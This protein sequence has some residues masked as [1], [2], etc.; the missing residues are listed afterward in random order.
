MRLA[1]PDLYKTLDALLATLTGNDLVRGSLADLAGIDPMV[2]PQ[3]GNLFFQTG[4][5]VE[6]LLHLSMGLHL[7][8][9]QAHRTALRFL[10]TLDSTSPT[11]QNGRRSLMTGCSRSLSTRACAGWRACWRLTISSKHPE[12]RPGWAAALSPAPRRASQMQRAPSR[13]PRAPREERARRLCA[14]FP[15]R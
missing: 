8:K 2:V 7:S 13:M 9:V 1:V 3:P 11:Q 4:P 12:P 6:E 5:G 10:P 15:S 14:M